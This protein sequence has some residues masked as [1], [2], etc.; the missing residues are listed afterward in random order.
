MFLNSLIC[1][2]KCSSIL[3]QLDLSFYLFLKLF[4]IYFSLSAATI[5]L[6][7]SHFSLFSDIDE[8]ETNSHHCNP[9][10]VCINTAGGYT[11]SCTEG[12]WLIAGQCQ[13]ERATFASMTFW[14][15]VL[16]DLYFQPCNYTP[17][18]LSYISK[19]SFMF[20]VF[21]IIL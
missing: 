14:Q 2:Y 15:M 4:P 13:G 11:C 12:Y 17:S 7:I 9:T 1:S 10:Q 6:M 3:G 18:H 8:C 21:Y 19:D 20:D 5:K 16:K